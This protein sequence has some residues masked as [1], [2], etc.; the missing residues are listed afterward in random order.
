MSTLSRELEEILPELDSDAKDH[1]ERLIRDAI[2][3]A[4]RKTTERETDEYGYP[5]GHFDRTFGSFAEEPFERP[6]Q[7]EPERRDEW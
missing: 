5:I 4:R 1:L 6:T 2:A 3:L 7:G